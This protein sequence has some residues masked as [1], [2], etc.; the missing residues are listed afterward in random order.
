MSW[1]RVRA[2][3]LALVNPTVTFHPVPCALCEVELEPGA[4]VKV[5]VTVTFHPV[6]CA[7]SVRSSWSPVRA[8]MLMSQ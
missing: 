4:G 8:L 6:P 5:N 1:S 2:Y 7:L 3:M